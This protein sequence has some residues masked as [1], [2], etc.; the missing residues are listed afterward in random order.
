KSRAYAP[1]DEADQVSIRPDF[2]IP[3]YPGHLTMEH[4]NKTP[5][6]VA[7]QELNT[8]VV[9][10]IDVPTTLLV[11]AKDDPTDPSYYSEVYARELRKAGVDV[12]VNLYETGGH[13]F[14]VQKQGT[15]TDRW[16]DDAIEWLKKIKVL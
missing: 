2:A 6:E 1:I 14:G 13:A 10:S 9:V 4:R 11:H 12:E 3:V 8:D 5:K 7:A 15:D 16:M